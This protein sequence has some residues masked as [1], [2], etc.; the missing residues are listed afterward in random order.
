MG[1]PK[2]WLSS[3]LLATFLI[4]ST[5]IGFVADAYAKKGEKG[6]NKQVAKS[7][8]KPD[9]AQKSNGKNGSQNNG[10]NGKSAN[11]NPAGAKV[12]ICH[13]GKKTL[14]LPS[15]ALKGHLGHGDS[16]GECS[17]AKNTA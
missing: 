7:T 5:G 4:N 14:H 11:G 2:K 8:G 15:S 9:K 1:N 16:M 12:A 13:K 17:G 6:N 10:G 3:L